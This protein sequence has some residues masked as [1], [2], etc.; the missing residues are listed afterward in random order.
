[1]AAFDD[2]QAGTPA[3]MGAVQQQSHPV[4]LVDSR[5]AERGQAAIGP[6][7]API[8]EPVGLAVGEDQHPQTKTVEGLN[9]VELVA[10]EISAL[11]GQKE[12]G[13]FIPLGVGDVLRLGGDHD[14]GIT[15]RHVMPEHQSFKGL[16]KGKMGV[17]GRDRVS[18]D[19]VPVSVLEFRVGPDL[20]AGVDE[21]IGMILLQNGMNASFTVGDPA[22]DL[23]LRLIARPGCGPD[24]RDPGHLDEFS[25]FHAVFSSFLLDIRDVMTI[26]WFL[27]IPHQLPNS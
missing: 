4:A 9:P 8:A 25:S 27:A 22:G 6:V 23:F 13:L 19:P 1:L 7:Q 15:T 3:D 21:D 18:R 11:R 17:P 5:L 26:T 10:D 20:H 2:F 24:R 16:V 14:I 12:R